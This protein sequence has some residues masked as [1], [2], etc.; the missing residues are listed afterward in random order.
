MWTITTPGVYDVEAGFHTMTAAI[1]LE[2]IVKKNSIAA[3][4][5]GTVL[6]DSTTTTA[7]GGAA[8]VKGRI[9]LNA[10]DTLISAVRT[11]AAAVWS[12]PASNYEGNASFFGLRY[13]EPLR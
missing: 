7:V 4:V 5:V 13:V 8:S 11:S 3:D 9:R 2:F 6:A 10:G 1:T 12:T